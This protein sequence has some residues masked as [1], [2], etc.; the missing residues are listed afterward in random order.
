MPALFRN[1]GITFKLVF[2]ILV[3]D[4]AV[5]TFIFGYNYLVSRQIIEKNIGENARNLV[6]ATVNRIDNV[7]LPVEMVPEN[8]AHFLEDSPALSEEELKALLRSVVDNNPDIYGA[9]VAFEPNAFKKDK[10]C[11]APYYC[12]KGGKLTFT[13][14][15]CNRYNYFEWDWYRIPRQVRHPVWSEPYFDRGGGDIMMSTYSVPFYRS[16]DGEKRFTG[17][18]TADIGLEWLE[19]MVSAIKIAD[20]GY[21]FLISG[22]GTFL[23]HPQ[24][25]LIMNK[26]IFDV[27]KIA[28]DSD[29]ERVGKAMTDGQS[30][31]APIISMVTGKQCWIGYAPLAA[32]N[33]SLG[34]LFPQDELTAD[35]THLN[36]VVWGLG[37]VGFLLL[38]AVIIV[39]ARSITRPLRGLA[40]ATEEISSGNLDVALP[41]IR[42][43]DEVGVLAEAFAQMED[44][45]KTYIANLTATT[46]AKERIESELQVARDI[47]M[48][49]LPKVFPP[50]PEVR[51]IDLYAAIEPARQ[52][53]GDLYDFFFLDEAHLCFTVGD[54][55]GKGVPAALLMTVTQTLIKAKGSAMGLSPGKILTS[56]NQDLCLEN[57]SF[58]FV[59]L[60]LGILNIQTGELDYCSGGHPAP[61]VIPA[62]GRVTPLELTDGLALGIAADAPYRSKK[63]ELNPNDTVFLYTDGVT[64]AMNREKTL[65]SQKRLEQDLYELG[66]QDLEQISAGIME[67]IRIFSQ[68]EPQADDITML[69]VRY[70]GPGHD[71]SD[72]DL[73]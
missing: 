38:M 41:R 34:V 64:E 7:L 67:R 51:E 43:R 71:G 50:F 55:A 60:F 2:L 30:G 46:A 3:S 20:S 61:L 24:T 58:M 40:R 12:K 32:S 54:V 65:F 62:T 9:T 37:A 66:H 47:Q 69:I 6:R 25:R 33:W 14:L 19:K 44:A 17:I 8:L 23:T 48:G 18:V 56:V 70:Q 22:K 28:D 45:L 53:G 59:T 73:A 26:T 52:V 31:F 13:Y 4:A 10:R 1:R 5:L 63:A 21:G 68:G 27:A 39:I 57:P 49:M 42:S 15:N 72:I 11:F 29:L 16:V 35:I 36:Q